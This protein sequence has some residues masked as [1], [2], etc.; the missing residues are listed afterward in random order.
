MNTNLSTRFRQW[1]H[2]LKAEFASNVN[3][4]RYYHSIADF[5]H[6]SGTQV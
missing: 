2:V 4:Y 1:I 6:S 3:R 5:F